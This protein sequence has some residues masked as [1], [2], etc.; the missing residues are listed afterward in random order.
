MLLVVRVLRVELHLDERRLLR[1]LPVHEGEFG[2]AS[3]GV[4]GHQE[5]P[6]VRPNRTQRERYVRNQVCRA[7]ESHGLAGIT[8]CSAIQKLS[9]RYGIMLLCG[10]LAPANASSYCDISTTFAAA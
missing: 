9:V 5:R 2:R 4:H 8:P 1:R 10:M 6:V 7:L 3:A